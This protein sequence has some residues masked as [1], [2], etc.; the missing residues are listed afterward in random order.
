LRETR[1]SK[2]RKVR[3][4]FCFFYTF[5]VLGPEEKQSDGEDPSFAAPG[6]ETEKRWRVAVQPE[7]R[8]EEGRRRRELGFLPC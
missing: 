7:R 4:G 6:R 8:E 1:D 2:K 5:T 3:T